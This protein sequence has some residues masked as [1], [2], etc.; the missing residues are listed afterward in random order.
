M[1]FRGIEPSDNDFLENIA[2]N[3]LKPIYGSQKKA[4][5]EW[6]IGGG[7][8]NTFIATVKREGVDCCVGFLS[9]KDN[10]KKSYLKISTLV[11]ADEKSRGCGYGVYLLEKAEKFAKEREYSRMVV[12]VSEEKKD[13]ISFFVRSGFVV[14][15]EILGKYRPGIKEVILK[16]ILRA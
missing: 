14:I 10:P 4:M 15:R 16:K 1:I 9:L 5:E 7:F 13:A 6:W 11:I 2:N 8:K 12:T 3:I